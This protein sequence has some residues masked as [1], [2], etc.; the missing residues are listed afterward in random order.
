MVHIKGF[1]FHKPVKAYQAI[2]AADC[3]SL[4]GDSYTINGG[5]IEHIGNN[6]SVEFRGMDF[7]PE[8]TDRLMLRW[9]SEL[10][11]NAVQI[12]F[13]DGQD[14]KR[15]LI[16]TDAAPAYKE[17]VF[18]LGE[19]VTGLQTVTFVFLPGCSLDLQTIQFILCGALV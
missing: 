4:Y 16:E 14:T 17:R 10:L 13:S 2:N 15:F 18:A 8:G 19:S 9:R 5:A 3:D 11:K 6:V 12:L 1:Q 7:G